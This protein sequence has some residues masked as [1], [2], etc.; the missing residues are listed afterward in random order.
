VTPFVFRKYFD[1]GAIAALRE[2]HAMIR[3]QTERRSAR[4][5]GGHAQHEDNIKLGRGGIREIE[6][7]A[8][9]F[10]IV[11]GGRDPRL[12]SRATLTTLASLAELRLLQPAVCAELAQAYEFLRRLEHALQYLDDAQTHQLPRS[13]EDLARVALLLREPDPQAL[14]ARC[15]Q[16]RERVAAV[17]DEQLL[18]AP[19]GSTADGRTEVPLSWRERLAAAGV[20]A[21]EAMADRIQALLGGRRVATASTAARRDID[22]LLAHAVGSLGRLV[23]DGQAQDAAAEP[24]EAL[25]RLLRL[26]EAIAGRSTYLALL[27]QYPRA[28]D[29]VMRLLQASGWAADYLVRHPILL[30]ELLD[31]RLFERAPD[32]PTWCADLEA[33][34]IVR[35]DQEQQMNLLRDAHHAQ[36]FRLLVADLEGRLTVE[37]LADHLS[38][39]ADCTLGLALSCAW[40][41]LPSRHCESPAFAVVAFG[42]L[43]GKELGYASDLD[44]IFLYDDP[45]PDAPETYALLVR[46]LMTWLTSQTSSGI[47]FEIDLRLRPNGNAG[48][49][50][51]SIDAFER[52]ERNED[53]LGAW[54]WEHQALTR[55]RFCAGNAALGG[56]FESLREEILCRRRDPAHLRSEVLAMRQKMLDGHPNR[57]S[58]FDLKHDRGG[59]VDIEF[60]VQTL[61]LVFAHEHPSLLRNAG[62][63]ALLRIAGDLGIIESSLA[64]RVAGAY[65]SFRLLQHRLRLNNVPYAR[66]SPSQ[67]EAEVQAVLALWQEVFD[68]LL[69]ALVADAPK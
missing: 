55:A 22:T 8:Q 49:L 14:L 57:S 12:R 51:S 48:L 10:Q 19:V 54:T 47:L 4:R 2:V 56:R 53:R 64:D 65:R 9:T 28:L 20:Q 18:A 63:I 5:A 21:P 13:E 69:P 7:I 15:R 60:I 39:L 3:A 16:V 41:G 37:V 11:R 32:W 66:T 43:G 58:Q 61:V 26:I 62:N 67:V 59:M 1:F 6:F 50:V 42:K 45:H 17:F 30:D 36:V 46:R 24:E 52:Y 29:R 68:R 35:D 23:H 34:L 25:A 33:G 40:A 44:L 27:A 31:E 38:A